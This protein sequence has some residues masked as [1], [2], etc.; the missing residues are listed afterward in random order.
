MGVLGA[1][2]VS[3]G[4]YPRSVFTENLNRL[5]LLLGTAT[6]LMAGFGMVELAFLPVTL[7]AAL[8]GWI[9]WDIG[10]R[11]PQF[12]LGF[13]SA[14]LRLSLSFIGPSVLFLL[15]QAAMALRLQGSTLLVGSVLGAA[16]VAGFVTTRTLANAVLQVV[17]ALQ[18]AIWPE[19]TSLHAT[20]KQAELRELLSIMTK[21]ML[22]GAAVAATILYLSGP[23]L[24]EFWTRGR[25]EYD[26]ALMS[27]FLLGL[28]S[29]T[30]WT[31]PAVVLMASNH[32]RIVAGARLASVFGGLLLGAALMPRFGLAGVAYGLFAVDLLLCGWVVSRAACRHV[33]MSFGAFLRGTMLRGMP[34]LA[35]CFTLVALLWQVLPR[36]WPAIGA[37]S[38]ITPALTVAAAYLLWLSH[39]ERHHLNSVIRGFARDLA[40]RGA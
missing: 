14:D 25:L 21:T 27:G 5:G 20:G 3:T 34:I 32:Q 36:G 6:A 7:S 26:A 30:A 13:R 31:F 16:A 37:I 19:V 28:L 8:M 4:N 29:E 12:R 40:M 10:R 23:A 9:L 38:V 1:V 22:T 17:I 2:Y 35:G 39:T 24:I 15:I 11:F 33:A 18:S